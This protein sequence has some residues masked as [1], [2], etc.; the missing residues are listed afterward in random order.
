M[1]AELRGKGSCAESCRPTLEGDHVS[2][3]ACRAG[4]IIYRRCEETGLTIDKPVLCGVKQWMYSD[5]SRSISFLYQ[6]ERFEGELRSSDEGNVF[7]VERDELPHMNLASGMA[8]TL[9]VFLEPSLSELAY[10]QKS[11][12]AGNGEWHYEDWDFYL[13]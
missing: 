5:G 2:R 3:R 13:Q 11:G 10:F 9:R 4:R 6:A 12:F 8:E 1:Y 7:W